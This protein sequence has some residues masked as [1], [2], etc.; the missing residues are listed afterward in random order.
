MSGEF[1]D[2]VDLGHM[3]FNPL[4]KEDNRAVRQRE[5]I[6]GLFDFIRISVKSGGCRI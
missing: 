4:R 2:D 5:H 3:E 6:Y 1:S